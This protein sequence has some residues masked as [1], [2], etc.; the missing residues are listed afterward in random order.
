[1]TLLLEHLSTISINIPNSSTCNKL[2]LRN[3]DIFI[4]ALSLPHSMDWISNCI[5]WNL[6]YVLFTPEFSILNKR[7]FIV[8]STQDCCNHVLI[9]YPPYSCFINSSSH[10]LFIHLFTLPKLFTTP[11]FKKSSHLNLS[12]SF[13]S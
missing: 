4:N 10:S 1:M 5:T 2:N 13:I 7:R 11:G 3:I 9:H 8:W 6:T 12:R